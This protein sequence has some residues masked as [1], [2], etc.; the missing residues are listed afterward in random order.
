MLIT[1]PKK[2][3]GRKYWQTSEKMLRKKC[4]Q[5]FQKMSTK[6]NLGNTPKNVDEK[7]LRA[8]KK[9]W[10]PLKKCWRKNVCTILRKMLMKKYRQQ[11]EKSIY[12]IR[13]EDNWKLFSPK[14]GPPYPS[15]R[16]HPSGC[17]MTKRWNNYR[18]CNLGSVSAKK[19]IFLSPTPCLPTLR[20]HRAHH[21]P[22]DRDTV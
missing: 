17:V 21:L 5:H 12:T 18:N 19:I 22:F 6:K 16:T 9:C 13:S 20:T 4:W 8:L 3:D 14:S 1:L 15:R 2:V 7:M 11:F 10:Q